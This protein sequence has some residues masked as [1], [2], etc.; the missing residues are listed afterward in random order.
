[1]RNGARLFGSLL[2]Q[3]PIVW[4]LCWVDKS[5]GSRIK[6]P[7]SESQLFHL[8][9]T[10]F[11]QATALQFPHLI[12]RAPTLKVT[13]NEVGASL[14]AQRLKHLPAMWDTWVQSLG[15]EDPQEKE[16][17]THSSI[18]A[19]RIPW[20]E[21]P[22]MG[23]QR[24]GRDWATKQQQQ[25]L[26]FAILSWTLLMHCACYLIGTSCLQ[27]YYS[28]SNPLYPISVIRWKPCPMSQS[29]FTQIL[30]R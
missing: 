28:P 13:V 11:W 5:M 25:Q 22:G 8:Q 15:Q 9:V 19:W 12:R 2:I 18:L 26:L 7:E 10:W 30:P 27:Y 17:A 21:E 29:I 1:M 16:M 20:T 23:S 3:W 6:F 4:K 14:V 24:V